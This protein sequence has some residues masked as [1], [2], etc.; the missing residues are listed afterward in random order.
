MS[1]VMDIHNYINA[2]TTYSFYNSNKTPQLE[3]IVSNTYNSLK[4]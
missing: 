4:E 3:T 1:C 2:E